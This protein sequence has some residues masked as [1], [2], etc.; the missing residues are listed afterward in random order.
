MDQVGN[1]YESGRLIASPTVGVCVFCLPN[2]NSS[3]DYRISASTFTKK[4][5][6]TMSIRGLTDWAPFFSKVLAPK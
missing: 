3:I 1:R 6:T 2:N 4:I 5:A